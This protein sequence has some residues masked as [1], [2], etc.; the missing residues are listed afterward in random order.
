MKNTPKNEVLK[1]I[2]NVIE[3]MLH[4]HFLKTFVSPIDQNKQILGFWG[5]GVFTQKQVL[6]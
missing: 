4:L 6:L 5:D 2:T 1:K 3:N